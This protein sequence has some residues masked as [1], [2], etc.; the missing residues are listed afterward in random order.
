VTKA[1]RS[2]CAAFDEVV[3]APPPDD[4][5]SQIPQGHLRHVNVEVTLISGQSMPK[6]DV[7]GK[8]DA[9][10]KLSFDKQFFESEVIKK[11]YEPGMCLH[12]HAR[13]TCLCAW[14]SLLQHDARVPFLLCSHQPVWN[15][16]FT[17]SAVVRPSSTNVPDLDIQ[18]FDFD[19]ATA[20]DEIGVAT[21][22]GASILKCCRA[23]SGWTS[24]G[25]VVVKK[26][27]EVVTGK[28]GGPTRHVEVNAR[29]DFRFL[30]VCRHLMRGA[31]IK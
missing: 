2:Q 16:A 30:G 19:S 4:V 24:Q 25:D 1:L 11:S 14:P 7:L 29:L 27:D 26:D 22:A 3:F 21:V 9:F 17:F 13:C 8:C 20:A 18:L 15:Q 6:M 31:G 12:T 10:C 23:P 28:D 5:L